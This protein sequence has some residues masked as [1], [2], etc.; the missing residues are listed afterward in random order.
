M[1]IEIKELVVKAVVDQSGNNQLSQ[2]SNEADHKKVINASVEQVL[3]ILKRQN[4]R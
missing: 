3:A 2:R 4:Q 1:T